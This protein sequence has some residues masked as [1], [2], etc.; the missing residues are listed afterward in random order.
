MAGGILMKTHPFHHF[1]L[2]AYSISNICGLKLTISYKRSSIIHTRASSLRAVHVYA[3]K[4]THTLGQSNCHR[5]PAPIRTPERSSRMKTCALIQSGRGVPYAPVRTPERSP[6]LGGQKWL[7]FQYISI[8]VALFI[9]FMAGIFIMPLL[10]WF[11]I[12]TIMQ[13]LA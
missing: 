6:R 13:K 2:T 3:R 1:L 11:V 10:K 5:S 9:T 7:L 8:P 12:L 4:D